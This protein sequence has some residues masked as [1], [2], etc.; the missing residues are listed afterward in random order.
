MAGQI[1]KKGYRK[2]LV[3]VSLGTD[4]NGKR[5]LLTGGP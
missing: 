2:C 1:I 3:R 5:K 4:A